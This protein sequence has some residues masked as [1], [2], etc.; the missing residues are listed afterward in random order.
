MALCRFAIAQLD[1]YGIGHEQLRT[2]WKELMDAAG[3]RA[4][5]LEALVEV[6]E[7]LKVHWKKPAAKVPRF[8]FN[9]R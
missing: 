7:F 4:I 8:S 2:M 9:S 1:L 3:R 5:R 6:R